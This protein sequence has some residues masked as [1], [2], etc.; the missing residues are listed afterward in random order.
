MKKLINVLLF[1]L[2]ILFIFSCKSVDKK[3][4]DDAVTTTID[5]SYK[6]AAAADAGNPMNN[7]GIGP[8]KERFAL[9]AIDANKA[10]IGKDIFEAK[11]T[12]C[13][14]F[15]SDKYVGPGLLG[16]TERR[17]PE[18]IVNQICNPTEMT[19]K[20]PIAHELLETYL[21]QMTNQDITVDQAKNILEYFRQQDAAHK[22]Q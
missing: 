12:S 14:K 6:P 3:Q 2:I 19:E 15:T 16:V 4:N 11:C 9:G 17:S 5:D 1:S 21:T 8:V 18:W 20:D 10:T 13:H 7:I 22:A